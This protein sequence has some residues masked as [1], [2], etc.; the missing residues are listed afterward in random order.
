M[1]SKRK[2]LSIVTFLLLYLAAWSQRANCNF[3]PTQFEN[4]LQKYIVDHVRLTPQE[5]AKFFPLYK[6]MRTKQRYWFQ[7]DKQNRK[8]N[9][10]DSRACERAVRQ[11]D[12][13][14]IQLKKIQ[15]AYHNKFL[16]ILPANKVYQIIKAEEEFHRKKFRRA[17]KNKR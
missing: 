13:N 2:Y 11:H 10:N 9:P 16:K 14:E 5:S 8:I 7:R 17:V 12:E 15:Q 3:N 4:E 1:N 6:E